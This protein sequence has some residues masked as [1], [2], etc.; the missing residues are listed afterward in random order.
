VDRN[1]IPNLQISE[2]KY[3]KG[4]FYVGGV[5]VE[6]PYW[7]GY[8]ANDDCTEFINHERFYI[9]IDN[10][11]GY[12]FNTNQG[13]VNAYFYLIENHKTLKEK[14]IQSLKDSLPNLLLNEY[15]SFDTTDFPKVSQMTPEFDFKGFIGPSSINIEKDVKDDI[16]YV[17]WHFYCLWDVEHGFDI[18]TH[19]DRI[20]DISPQSDKFII[21]EDN[22]TAEEMKRSFDGHSLKVNRK[23]K[24][25]KFW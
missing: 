18:I 4:T 16:A 22:G 3:R 9:G 11:K 10:C 24:W 20:L 2:T 5:F 21:N 12:G 25:W 8:M 17:T 23:R 1:S 15:S 14:I 13:Q 6:L 19:K 7:L